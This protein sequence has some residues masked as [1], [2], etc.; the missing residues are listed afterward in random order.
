[1]ITNTQSSV[2]KSPVNAG[3]IGQPKEYASHKAGIFNFHKVCIH[4]KQ[5]KYH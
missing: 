4:L 5:H 3:I 2:S 1:M